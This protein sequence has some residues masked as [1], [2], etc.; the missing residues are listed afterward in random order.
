MTP[1]D[2][3]AASAAWRA[4][5]IRRGE[6]WAYRCTATTLSGTQCSRPAKSWTPTPSDQPPRCALH[7]VKCERSH[8]NVN[9]LVPKSSTALSDTRYPPTTPVPNSSS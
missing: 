2:F 3:D 8:S 9:V 1:E 5:K 6:S 4:N 7:T